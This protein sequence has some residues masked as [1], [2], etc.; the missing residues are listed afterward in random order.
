MFSLFLCGQVGIDESGFMPVTN[1][2]RAEARK[3][4]HFPVKVISKDGMVHKGRA[5][6]ISLQGISVMLNEPF[7]GAPMCA[8][9]FEA[10]VKGKVV[11]VSVAAEAVYSICV[12]TEGFRIGFKFDQK[13]EV[14]A[15]SIRL[16]L[17]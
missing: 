10:L 13:N 6:D 16:L 5:L 17:E 11:S 2:A 14:A 4:L 9:V 8:M 15:K 12:G 1:E 7:D 3:R